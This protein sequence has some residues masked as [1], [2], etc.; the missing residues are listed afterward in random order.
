LRASADVVAQIREAIL[1]G[2]VKPGDR[3]PTERDMAQQFGVSRVTIRDA[4]RALEAGGLIRVKIGGGG[5]PYVTQPDIGILRDSLSAHFQLHGATLRELAEARMALETT[6]A[7]L[8]AERATDEDLVALRSALTGQNPSTATLSLDFHTTLVGA[9]HNRALLIMF[10]ATRALIQEAF[11]ALHA[12]QP[13][14]AETARRVHTALYQAIEQRDA[15]R[16]VRLMREHMLD[17]A[18]RAER[19]EEAG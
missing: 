1:S 15:D 10:S 3:L 12:R 14:M 7:R 11:D 2:K 4:L 9:S 16:A 6:A 17:F 19:A 13:D 18:A 8:A 5:G